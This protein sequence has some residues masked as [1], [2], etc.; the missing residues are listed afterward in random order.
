MKYALLFLERNM[1][2]GYAYAYPPLN[3]VL[4]WWLRTLVLPKARA[5]LEKDGCLVNLGVGVE[6]AEF[7]H[8]GT[9]SMFMGSGFAVYSLLT[10]CPDPREKGRKSKFTLHSVFPVNLNFIS[11]SFQTFLS[12][13]CVIGLNTLQSG[14]VEALRIPIPDNLF[15]SKH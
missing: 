6:S 2:S 7:P 8:E 11:G 14:R 10:W 9:T 3:R 1:G 15:L 12:Q 4:S 13:C 5:T